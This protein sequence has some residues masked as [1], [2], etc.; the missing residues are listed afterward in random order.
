MFVAIRYKRSFS[1]SAVQACFHITEA[2]VS[3]RIKF[4]LDK[5]GRCGDLRSRLKALNVGFFEPR[6]SREAAFE[7]PA[8]LVFAYHASSALFRCF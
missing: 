5:R 3:H 8:M 7:Q 6:A 4:S 2:W 1:G